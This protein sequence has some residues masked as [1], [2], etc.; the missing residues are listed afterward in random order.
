MKQ[1]YVKK[2]LATIMITTSLSGCVASAD[3]TTISAGSHPQ[4]GQKTGELVQPARKI[5]NVNLKNWHYHQ[6]QSTLPAKFDPRGTNKATPIQDQFETGLCWSYAGS[7]ILAINKL[8]KTGIQSLFSTN[9]YNYMFA[10]NAFK[11][12]ENPF[13]IEYRG[14]GAGGVES[15]PT[16]AA[17]MGYNPAK[18][19]DFASLNESGQGSQDLATQ[20]D[21]TSDAFYQTP[22]DQS[23]SVNGFLQN[24]GAYDDA[25]AQAV[26]DNTKK[27]IKENGSVGYHFD[28]DMLFA[29]QLDYGQ[30]VYNTETSAINLPMDYPKYVSYT[31]KESGETGMFTAREA[32]HA[33]TI[34]GWDDNYSR[35]NFVDGAKPNQN[36]AFIVKNSWGTS[37]GEKGYLYVSY[38]DYFILEGLLTTAKIAAPTAD[39]LITSADAPASSDWSFETDSLYTGAQVVL[40]NVVEVPEDSSATKLSAIS[41]AAISNNAQYTVYYVDHEIDAQTLT[42][43]EQVAEVGTMLNSGIASNHGQIKINVPKQDVV[44]G[45]KITLIAVEQDPNGLVDDGAG[46]QIQREGARTATIADKGHNLV[47]WQQ[48]DGT[49]SWLDLARRGFKTYLGGYIH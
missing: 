46:F 8:N 31:V 36:G 21:V 19:S 25:S 26:V 2:V 38:E 23:F 32:N 22:T 4:F 3:V 47:A 12:L 34:V 9:Y 10:S 17:L 42:T 49:Y 37:W 1:L 5:D 39:T 40:A 15:W 43:P 13:G 24:D 16:M 44:A 11:D 45:Q 27:L 33:V 14:L 35:D 48:A 7:D 20:Y 28:G 29:D 6:N 41:L 30:A 18:E